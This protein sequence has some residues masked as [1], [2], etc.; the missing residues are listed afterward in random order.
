MSKEAFLEEVIHPELKMRKRR[1]GGEGVRSEGDEAS[2][3][4]GPAYSKGLV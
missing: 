3:A 4:E 1:P 2:W